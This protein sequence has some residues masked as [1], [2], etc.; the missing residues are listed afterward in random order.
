M[1]ATKKGQPGTDHKQEKEQREKPF[2]NTKQWEIE[3]ANELGREITALWGK[4]TGKLT[5]D[6]N[7]AWI[8]APQGKCSDPS[9]QDGGRWNWGREI[10]VSVNASWINA[11]LLLN[12]AERRDQVVGKGQRA[13]LWQ[14]WQTHCVYQPG[15]NRIV[16]VS[17]YQSNINRKYSGADLQSILHCGSYEF[18]TQWWT[19]YCYF[20]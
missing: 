12:T 13:P 17:P 14:V 6:Y 16:R 20:F 8:G 10:G 1:P 3:N 2:F 9:V 5:C 15:I 11:G 18:C 19:C 4:M 7:L